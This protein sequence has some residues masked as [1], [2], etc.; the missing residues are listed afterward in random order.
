MKEMVRKLTDRRSFLK[1]TAGVLGA[2]FWADETLEAALQNVNTASKPSALKIT[3]LRVAP[4][5]GG[6]IR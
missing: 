3:D 2:A 1:R 6:L 5:R 4:L